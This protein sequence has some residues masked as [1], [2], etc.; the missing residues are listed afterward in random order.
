MSNKERFI[1]AIRKTNRSAGRYE[2]CLLC[3]IVG[4]VRKP[5]QPTIKCAPCPLASP[6][7]DEGCWSAID[8]LD[9]K[10]AEGIKKANDKVGYYRRTIVKMLEQTPA[11]YFTKDGWCYFRKL[12][13]YID[14]KHRKIF[15][16]D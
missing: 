1:E 15:K 2:D 8:I 16:E 7:E 11:R 4:K 12:H 10:N 14:K 5:T 13:E 9:W 3:Q 6:G